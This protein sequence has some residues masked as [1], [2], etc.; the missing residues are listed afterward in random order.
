MLLLVPI[1]SAFFSLFTVFLGPVVIPIGVFCQVY[2]LSVDLYDTAT[3]L[4]KVLFRIMKAK[5]IQLKERVTQ[6]KFFQVI[7]DG[8][9]GF[10]QKIKDCLNAC[11]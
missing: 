5:L 9:Y 1:T 10:F 6:F 8:F 7:R 2:W 4:I 11:Y 3:T